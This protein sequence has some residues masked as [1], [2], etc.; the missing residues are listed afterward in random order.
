MEDN[1]S[2]IV[3]VDPDDDE[4]GR[5]DVVGELL[6][7]GLEPVLTSRLLPRLCA[8]DLRRCALVS[9]AWRRAT[10]AAWVR[11]DAVVARHWWSAGTPA[12]VEVAQ[13]HRDRATCTGTM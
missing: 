7:R 9:R 11:A 3:V 4:E 6:R 10:E 5:F 2:A 13:C 1:T 8:L 12:R